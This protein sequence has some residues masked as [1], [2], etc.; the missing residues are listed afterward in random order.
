MNTKKID[1]RTMNAWI[2]GLAA[3]RKLI[4]VQSRGERFAFAP[5]EKASDLRLDYDVTILP[6]T[7]F[8]RPQKE[9]ILSFNIDEGYE[10]IISAEPFVLFGVHPYD[11]AAIRQ[12]DEIFS[13]VNYD[14]HYMSRRENT[15]IVAADVQNV[16]PDV[17]AGYMG[18]S[19]VEKGYDVLLTRIGDDW[20]VDAK[21]KKGE[22]LISGMVDAPEASAS[23]LEQRKL[24]WEYNKQRMRKHEL[25]ADPSKWPDLLDDA[26]EHPVWED[27]ST[28]CFSCGS[29]N[30]VCPTC[31]CFDVREEIKWELSSGERVRVWD[32]CMLTDF[33]T[34]SG[35]HNFRKNPSARFRHRYY[36][37]GKYVPDKIGGEIACVG[38]GRCITACVAKIASPVDVINRLAEGK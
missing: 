37:K 33:A 28:L 12:M 34:V 23:W 2:D 30:L 4:G 21:T 1:A 3:N 7:S 35:N 6:P 26:Y 5:L 15:A 13:Q 27:R 31:Y 38:C 24:V 16:S 9:T 10:S 20:L 29:C 8:L 22:D 18:T 25:K 17:F 14:V 11:V 32:G 36:R 19:A